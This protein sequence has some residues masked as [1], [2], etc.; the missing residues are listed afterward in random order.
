[1]PTKDADDARY[2]AAVLAGLQAQ[3]LS[4][5]IADIKSRLHRLSP[6]EQAEEFHDLWGD[7]VALEQYHKALREQAAGALR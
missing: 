2:V 3:L 5:Q 4:R 6:I 7:L 1:L